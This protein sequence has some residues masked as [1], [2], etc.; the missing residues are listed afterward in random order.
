MDAIDGFFAF[1]QEVFGSCGGNRPRSGDTAANSST[2]I[3]YALF[4]NVIVIKFILQRFGVASIIANIYVLNFVGGEAA[5][6]E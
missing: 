2:R 3:K 5:R 6:N 4:V 1:I